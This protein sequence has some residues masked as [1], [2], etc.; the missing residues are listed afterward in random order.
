[1]GVEP[2]IQNESAVSFVRALQERGR[3]QVGATVGSLPD[4]DDAVRELDEA[5]R[6]ELA[7]D[8][9]ALVPEVA[10]W[11]LLLLYRACQA[12]VYRDIE[13]DAVRGWLTVPCPR[14]PAPDVCYSAD[15]ALRFLPDLIALARGV[16]ERDPLVEG[17][18][19]VAAAWPLSSVGVPGLTPSV[20]AGSFIGHPS[21][22]RLY[23]DRI[24]D[25]S[26]V[27][28]LADPAAC[29]AVR[30]AVGAFPELA[31]PAVAAALV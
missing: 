15:L 21:L 9:P 30:E 16:A 6:R 19:S 5:A 23:A 18:R 29:D 14:A 11:A 20:G 24:I 3:V 7:F 25:R 22:R 26:D 27:A 1:M 31:P 10:R 28:R 17:L 2:D 4:A 13:A 12:L 8:P